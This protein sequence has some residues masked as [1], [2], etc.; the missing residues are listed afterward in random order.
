MHDVVNDRG[1]NHHARFECYARASRREALT[2]QD[3]T[4]ESACASVIGSQ[5]Y[6]TEARRERS[7]KEDD[8]TV[9]RKT[10]FNLKRRFG[11]KREK[12]EPRRG[13]RDPRL[14]IM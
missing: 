8:A 6:R 7:R 9:A 11:F 10:V 2:G 13:Y 1:V 12:K 4:S 14:T 3:A 5:I